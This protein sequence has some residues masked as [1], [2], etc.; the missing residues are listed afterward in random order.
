MKSAGKAEFVQMTEWIA[1]SSNPQDQTL[2]LQSLGFAEN[3]EIIKEVNS[4]GFAVFQS[5][6]ARIETWAVTNCCVPHLFGL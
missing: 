6:V 3:P 5:N 2:L 4:F 1:N